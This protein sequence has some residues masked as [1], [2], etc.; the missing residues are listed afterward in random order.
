MTYKQPGEHHSILGQGNLGQ[1]DCGQHEIGSFSHA[2]KQENK[3]SRP[4]MRRIQDE[5]TII[6]N[7]RAGL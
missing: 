1:G 7:V 2:V 4:I 5:A 6:L 3:L